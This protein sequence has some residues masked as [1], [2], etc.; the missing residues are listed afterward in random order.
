M[1]ILFEYIKGKRKSFLLLFIFLIIFAVIFLLYNLPIEALCYAALLCA[2]IGIAITAS[3]FS[4]YY[5]KHLLLRTLETDI[6]LSIETLP[7]PHN[8]L[9]KDYQSLLEIIHKDKMQLVSKADNARSEM[10]DYYT[11]WAHQIKTPIA[12]MRLLLQS[13]ESDQNSE[14]ASE[15]FKIE[16]YVEMVL[17]YLRI[18]STSTDFVLKKHNL[19]NIVKQA[20]RKYAKLFIRKK[21]SLNFSELNCEVLTDEKWL[22]FVIEQ[23]LSNALKYSNKGTISIYMDPQCTKTLVIEDTGIGIEAED[24]PRVFEKGFTGYN[25]RADKKSTGIGLYLCRR[26]LTKLSH[27]ISIESTVGKGTLVKIRLDTVNM[28]FE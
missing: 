19:D 16:Q 6:T 22:I 14:L 4:S 21:I 8:L 9:E 28:M 7:A 27:T 17:Q 13:E 12:A 25:G 3:S 26:I 24:L 15:L 5:K 11:L 23:I 20:V 2:S 1:R 18:D 10:I